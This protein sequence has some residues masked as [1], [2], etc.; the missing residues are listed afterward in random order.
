VTERIEI[1]VSGAGRRI[2]GRLLPGADLI[3]GILKACRRHGVVYG[4]V[5]SAIG[6][7]REGGIVYPIPDRNGRIGIRYSDPVRIRGP[8][9]LLACQGMIGLTADGEPG[10]HLHGLTSDPEMTV[11]GGHFL[12]NAN[13]VLATVEILIQECDGVRM[14]REP[15]EETGFPLFKFHPATP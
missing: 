8:L 3:H 4:T 9:E 6:S 10:A 5:V 11:R 14:I 7:L 2:V 13:P 1:A 12:E 15:D